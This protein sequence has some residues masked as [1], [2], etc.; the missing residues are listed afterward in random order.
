M[1]RRLDEEL[2]EEEDE[3]AYYVKETGG[4]SVT[5]SS[6]AQDGRIAEDH[7]EDERKHEG[8]TDMG[9]LEGDARREGR[10]AKPVAGKRDHPN[11]REGRVDNK[12]RATAPREAG[13]EG[14]DHRVA[15]LIDDD[16][17]APEAGESGSTGSF[18]DEKL[19]S[20]QTNP[21]FNTAASTTTSGDDTAAFSNR[22]SSSCET[23]DVLES[24]EAVTSSAS[25]PAGGG[26][27]S[28]GTTSRRPPSSSSSSPWSASSSSNTTALLEENANKNAS[29]Q[30][31]LLLEKE[32]D[33]LEQNNIQPAVSSQDEFG[34]SKNLKTNS[35]LCNTNFPYMCKM[36]HKFHQFGV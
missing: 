24:S 5:T 20:N 26:R 2:W 3:G 29:S 11:L 28:R 19:T 10:R 16:D 25:L 4:G 36:H 14:D 7:Q 12:P 13:V 15:E 33:L 18:E 23:E 34:N 30:E 22:K 17:G 35:Y 31:K 27:K 32:T 9:V 21:I 6:C 8:D 1:E